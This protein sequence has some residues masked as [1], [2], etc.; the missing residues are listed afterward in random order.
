MKRWQPIAV[1]LVISG[2]FIYLALRR[3]DLAAVGTALGT[4]RYGYV[5]LAGIALVGTI[6]LRGIR[7][8]ILTE[9][10]LTITDAFWLFNI[11]FMF[12]NVLPAR[13][14]ELVRALLA[15]RRPH[16][17]FTSALSSIVVE[18]LFDMV[19]VAGLL[20]LSLLALP[21]PRW[22]ITAGVAMGGGALAGMIVLALTARFPGPALGVGSRLLSLA[23]GVDAEKGEGLLL[24]FIEG[25][26]G[27]ANARTFGL[28]LGVSLAAWLASG[29][30]AWLLLLAFWGDARMI[31]GMLAVA[32]A[33]LG[34]TIPAAPSGV[35]PFEA[36]VIGVL[37]IVG[38]NL[39]VSR[40]YAFA[41]HALNFAITSALGLLGLMREGVT[42]RQVAQE[43]RT[44]RD[45][46]SGDGES[47]ARAGLQ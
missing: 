22:A 21:L 13:L 23:P 34:V 41:L 10:R 35:G 7:W 38:R 17:R 3:A 18:R 37:G 25:L 4:A 11:G 14:G 6:A 19:C 12:N 27:V 31:E 28:G 1:G 29:A 44:L 33:G 26:G 43:A 39:D 9:G 45:G 20:G 40:S 36:A 46:I 30:T 2:V 8:S 24:P 15:G 47:H 32:A 5:A 42:F 16:M